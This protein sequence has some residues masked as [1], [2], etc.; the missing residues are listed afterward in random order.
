[1]EIYVYAV[2]TWG[3]G[4]EVSA[5]KGS[6]SNFIRIRPGYHDIVQAQPKPSTG[7][8]AVSRFD[9]AI[10]A[11]DSSSSEKMQTGNASFFQQ[12]LSHATAGSVVHC[13]LEVRI[14]RFDPCFQLGRWTPEFC[15]SKQRTT[16]HN[17]QPCITVIIDTVA[18]WTTQHSMSTG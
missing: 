2:W 11:G 5:S 9:M 6:A 10:S 15:H 1:M 14:F 18:L 8:H 17:G 16:S 7:P 13:K 12:L 4:I 3:S